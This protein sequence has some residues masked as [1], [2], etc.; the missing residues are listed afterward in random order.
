MSTEKDSNLWGCGGL[1]GLF[2]VGGIYYGLDESLFARHRPWNL[3][4]FLVTAGAAISSLTCF[5]LVLIHMCK[6]DKDRILAVVAAL[7]VP[8]CGLGTLVAFV[9][10]W[11]Q[12]TRQDHQER[13]NRE[14]LLLTMQWWTGCIAASIAV[15]VYLWYHAPPPQRVPVYPAMSGYSTWNPTTGVGLEYPGRSPYENSPWPPERSQYE[16]P[17]DDQKQNIGLQVAP[18]TDNRDR[19]DRYGLKGS[20]GYR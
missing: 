15:L 1:I 3:F 9:W 5:V 20:P 19:A 12:A 6:S 14:A 17:S 8:F 18:L 16:G 10:G 2:V 4:L 7:L 13:Q 11:I